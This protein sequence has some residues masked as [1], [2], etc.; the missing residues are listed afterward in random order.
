MIGMSIKN[1]PVSFSPV[2]LGVQSGRRYTW[3]RPFGKEF[4]G[5]ILQDEWLRGDLQ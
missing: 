1:L 3:Y 4:G 5:E 2:F